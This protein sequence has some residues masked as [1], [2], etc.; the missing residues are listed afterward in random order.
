MTA[1]RTR[2]ERLRA[3]R[4]ALGRAERATGMRT[5]LTVLAGGAEEGSAEEDGRGPARAEGAG[6][7]VTGVP[8][9]AAAGV[10]AGAGAGA[11]TGAAGAGAAAA[12]AGAEGPVGPADQGLA[13]ALGDVLPVPSALQPLL[14]AGLPRGSVVQ[15]AGS[16]SL[17]LALAG[18]A[19][20][21]GAWC[22]MTAVPDVGWRAAA[23][24]GLPLDRVAVVPTLGPDAPMVLAALADGFDV[25]VLGRC[26][27]L[28][29]RDRRSLTARLRVREAVL[30]TVHPWPDAH[31]VLTG[32]TVGLRGLDAGPTGAGYLGGVD[33]AV[34]AEGRLAV[35]SGTARHE[36]RV[37]LSAGGIHAAGPATGP[38]SSAP[39]RTGAAADGAAPGLPLGA[40]AYVPARRG[41]LP[42]ALRAV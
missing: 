17:L 12:A 29:D 21:G 33:L 4:E 3:A 28:S 37:R 10:G 35:R 36:L 34:R 39:G 38:V 6:A 32:R 42:P 16:T 2:A 26:R 13:R 40:E 22:A 18:A 19:C 9:T 20:G 27:G 41:E 5:R 23:A 31:A 25:L 15:V 14:P 24:V 30:L 1:V 7:V 11:A 8:G